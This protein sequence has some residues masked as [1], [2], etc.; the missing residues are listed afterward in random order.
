MKYLIAVLM[1]VAFAANAE[2]FNGRRSNVFVG[3]G[4]VNV[5]QRGPFGGVRS[6]VTVQGHHGFNRG[7]QF[8]QPMFFCPI[9]QQSFQSFHSFQSFG[10]Q[11]GPFGY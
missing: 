2:A 4:V 10:G 9:Q 3:P 6:N 7:V 5:Q 8:S 1:L 11:C